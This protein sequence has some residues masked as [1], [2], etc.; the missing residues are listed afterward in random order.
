MLVERLGA[1]DGV[2]EWVGPLEDYKD[3]NFNLEQWEPM[4]GVSRGELITDLT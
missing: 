2:K 1:G 3:F 4:E